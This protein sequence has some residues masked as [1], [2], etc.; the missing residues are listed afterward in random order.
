M[1]PAFRQV[2]PKARVPSRFCQSSM[3]ATDSLFWAARIAA[4]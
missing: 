3:Q 1:Q 2:P 4:G